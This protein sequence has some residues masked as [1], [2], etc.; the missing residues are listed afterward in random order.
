L[1]SIFRFL[2]TLLITASLSAQTSV[3]VLEL[4]GKGLTEMEAS[5]LTDR[6]RHELFQTGK[7]R[8]VER[9]LMGEILNEQGFQLSECI[10]TECMVEIGQLLGVD[11]MVGGSVSKFGTMYTIA[12]RL[13]S[14]ETGEFLGTGKRRNR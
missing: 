4:E 8:V 14:V 9:E 12:V 3:A 11:Q 7:Y 10:S 1:R 5:I 6:L 2:L 13:V